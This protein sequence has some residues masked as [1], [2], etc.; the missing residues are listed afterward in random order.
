MEDLEF[1]KAVLSIPTVTGNEEQMV[2]FIADWLKTN[3]IEHYV[4]EYQNVY[5]IKQTG[6]IPD[7][8]MFPCVVAHTDTVHNIDTINVVEMT[9][10]NYQKMLKPA[11]KAFN[12][13]GQPTGIGGDDKCGVF[14]CLKL[15]KELPNLKAAFFV[16]EETGCHGSRKA[17]KNFFAN[18]GYAIQFDAPQNN[19][20]SESCMGTKLFNRDSEFFNIANQ[21]LTESVNGK[22]EYAA[23][24]YTD[25]W[26]LKYL[27][28]FSCIN[29]S[30]GYYDYH[31]PREYVIIEDVFNGIDIGKK[32]IDQLGYRKHYFEPQNKIQYRYGIF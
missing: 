25:V 29:I 3:N 4:D 22:L 27:F 9:L 18:V 6:E 5:A 24:P 2:Q 31:S 32:L 28:D 14:A 12:D 1:L 13:E 19:L 21:V 20:V 16:S 10:R 15:L 30:I 7:D 23:H 8:F 17:D 11:L 26:P